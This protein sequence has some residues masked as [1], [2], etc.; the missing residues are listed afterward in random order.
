MAEKTHSRAVFLL[1]FMGAGKTSVGQAL[2]H[3]LGWQFVDLDQ[4]I[5][6]QTGVAIAEI[7]ARSGEEA[8]RR[9][10]TAALRELLAELHNDSPAVVALGGGAPLRE[11]N[12]TLLAGCGAPQVFLDAPFEVVR[13]RCGATA[14]ARPLFREEEPA[15]RLY[16]TRRPHYLR[17]QFRVDTTARSVEQ[18]AAE[19]ARLLALDPT[20]EAK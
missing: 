2:A 12:A 16:E 19:I 10:E 3:R 18:A 5:E 6:L 11:E 1:G 13:Q 14:A 17:A 4:R 15:R 20:G 7:F 9:M 8:F